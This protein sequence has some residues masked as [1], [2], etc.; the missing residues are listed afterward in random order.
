MFKFLSSIELFVM[1]WSR[2]FK[3]AVAEIWR[4]MV[5]LFG[6]AEA[7]VVLGQSVGVH[8]TRYIDAMAEEVVIVVILATG[9]SRNS[10]EWEER[11]E[12]VRR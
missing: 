6:F 8:H 10:R 2:F 4:R 7:G 9:L 5:P 11:F 1:G 12:G 3:V